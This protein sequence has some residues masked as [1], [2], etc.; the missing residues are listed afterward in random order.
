MVNKKPRLIN[1][2]LS[3]LMFN[4]RV[5]QEA[6]DKTVPLIERL[7][8]LGIFSNNM[9][10]F[11]RVRVANVRRITTIGKQAKTILGGLKPKKLIDEIERSVMRLQK[12]FEVIH[13]ELLHELEKE[14]IYVINENQ[15]NVEQ[16]DYVR[17]FYYEKVSPAL[18][19]IMLNNLTV[20]PELRDK[21]IYLAI[22][23][24]KKGM[25]EPQYALIEVPSDILP[26]FNVL[27]ADGNKKYIIYLEDII[28]YHLH[29][30]FSIFKFDTIEAHTIK[31]TRDAELDIDNDI[32]RSFIEKISA[33]VKNRKKGD[34]VRFV[35]DKRISRDMLQFIMK[36]LG[37]DNNDSIIPGARYHN[38]K[39]YIKFPNI[40]REELEYEPIKNLPHPELRPAESILDVVREKDILLY[41]PYQQF[42]HFIK[43]LREAAIDPNVTSIQVTLYRV[44]SQSRVV[45]SL[46]NAVKNGKQVTVVIE[47]QARFDEEANIKWTRTLR[48]EGVNVIFGVSGLK[49]HS[50]LVCIT[51]KEGRR[52]VKYA[53]VSTGNFNEST[54]KLY[55]DYTIFTADKRITSEVVKVFDFFDNNYKVYDY[56]HLIVSPHYTRKKFIELID[57][58]I[59]HARKGNQASIK[60]KTN[61][62]VDEDM[63]EKLYEANNY[64]VK[65]QLIIRGMCS[66]I[67][68]VPGM[69]ENIEAISIVDKFLEHT[70]LYIFNNGGKKRYFI[71]SADWM[72]RNLDHRVE[73][74]CPV[75][76]KAIQKE[77]Q[78]TYDIMWSDNVKARYHNLAQDNAYRKEGE[79]PVRSQFATYEYY[80]AKSN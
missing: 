4:A 75:Y 22:K 53:V 67:P 5:L 52:E 74:T 41:Y 59:E 6:A 19:I 69:S 46:I 56:Q 61:S 63:I 27:P 14:N 11:F 35:Y 72:S 47:L 77:L 73:V 12:E 17:K 34:P 58:E 71:S 18:A 68:G 48:S 45:N 2:E 39:D 66:L 49:V 26:R 32:S 79:V 37:I 64:G 50:K 54:A 15:L 51:R 43:L 76:D 13:T 31:L 40:G 57:N 10:E 36:K 60:I 80:K 78:D 25:A 3:W 28:R 38:K 65:I 70:R 8:F 30:L 62:L 23:C 33:S 55:T 16:A 20:F 21:S 44:A 7:R 24:M 1:R 42:T 9:D 29:D